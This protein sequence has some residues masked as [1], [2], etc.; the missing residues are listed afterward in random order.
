MKYALLVATLTLGSLE[1]LA[2]TL[3]FGTPEVE[4]LHGGAE[5]ATAA[6][7]IVIVGEG[8]T[9]SQMPLFVDSAR[10][11]KDAILST[12]PF[13]AYSSFLKIWQVNSISQQ[14]GVDNPAT[15]VYV[16]T[17]FDGIL[18][19]ERLDC[20]SV[21]NV[22]LAVN[23]IPD[24]NIVIVICNT[25]SGRPQAPG[26]FCFVSQ[27]ATLGR[28][29][30]HELGHCIAGLA[31][32]YVESYNSDQ[33][34][35]GTTEPDWPNLT[36]QRSAGACKWAV[37]NG[38]DAGDGDRVGT[39]EGGSHCGY[40]VF[41]PTRTHCRMRSY[42]HGFCPVCREALIRALHAAASPITASS[43]S[44]RRLLVW[45]SNP[46]APRWE[47][48]NFGQFTASL[49]EIVPDGSTTTFWSVD[50]SNRMDTWRSD[51]GRTQRHSF[52]IYLS[53]GWHT[54]TAWVIDTNAQ[55]RIG[56]SQA[57]PYRTVTWRFRQ[58]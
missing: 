26:S 16:D 2:G 50:G 58:E 25:G 35:N 24:R 6:L 10:R 38:E 30:V 15:G 49:D 31:D 42:L 11:V 14:S 43:G 21:T 29:A 44:P 20:R 47:W 51:L 7:D 46:L 36:L 53:P 41:R 22:W 57:K 54:V 40:G 52:A 17:C 3:R 37:W 4:K 12:P 8:Y 5:Q 1:A 13:D 9:A 45:T 33:V 48:L 55:L 27:T 56:G 34:Y 28:V 23:G 32:E 18:D 39:N 19:G